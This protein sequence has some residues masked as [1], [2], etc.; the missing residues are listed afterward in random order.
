[1][2]LTDLQCRNSKPT[3]K[4]Q[5]LFD[6]GG[7]YLE[8][9]PKGAKHWRLK[10]RYLGKEKKL[11]IGPYPLYPLIEAREIRDMVKKQLRSGI[12]PA[13]LKIA[14]RRRKEME[15]N[16][17]FEKVALAWAAHNNNVWST[18]HAR[19]VETRLNQDIFLVIGKKPISQITAIDLLG[20]VRKIEKREAYEVARRCLQYCSQIF[21]FAILNGH[22]DRNPA[23]DLKGALKSVPK[24]NYAAFDAAELP[25]FIEKF[26]R[27]DARLFP[28]TR[29]AVE[30]MMLTFVRTSELIKATWDEFD[31]EEGIWRIP[32]SKMKMKREH[33]VPLSSQAIILLK[34]LQEMNGKRQWVFPSLRTHRKH[35]S[36][37]TI[38]TALARMG[39]RGIMTGHGFRSLAMST[40]M[41]KLDYRFEVPDR[42]LAHKAKGPLGESYNRAQFLDERKAMMQDWADYIDNSVI[43]R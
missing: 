35:M 31:L 5:K 30:L 18:N 10:Y 32:A 21:R 12:D 22:T 11:C 40:V 26:R 20:V 9:T 24:S 2:A 39:Y 27:N 13:A 43:G 37:N 42:Q 19:T 23:P 33:L 25:N 3:D 15:Q 34:Q 4:A 28:Q 36:N 8:I 14:E 17:T 38:L 29:I 6:G 7:L 1:M 41:E 16:N